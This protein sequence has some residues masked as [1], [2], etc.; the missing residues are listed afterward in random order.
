MKTDVARIAV[1]LLLAMSL[2]VT[3]VQAEG[4]LDGIDPFI[5]E[6]IRNGAMPGAVVLVARNGVVVKEQAYGYA[7][8]FADDKRTPLGPIPM[9]TDT[10][11]DIASISKLFTAT[12]MMQL[13]DQG[14]F[15]LDDPVV[16]YLPEFAYGGREKQQ[17]T[18]RQLMTHSSGFESWLPLYERGANRDDRIHAVLRHPL[19]GQ[20]GSKCVYS[21]LNLIVLGVLVEELSGQRLDAYVRQ[22]ITEPLGLHDTMY[23][24]PP[25]LRPRIAATEYQRGRGLVWGRVHDENAWSFDGVAGHAGVFSTARDLTVFAQMMLNGG[26]YQGKRI[27]SSS[28]V[29][30]MGQNHL[31]SKSGD[32]HGLGWELNQGWYMDAL[33]DPF[34]LGHTGFTGTSIVVSPGSGTIL[35]VLTNRV[36][37]TRETPSINPVRRGVARQV[38]LSIP[39]PIPW[40]DGAW[41]AGMGDNLQ[42]TMTLAA[43][44][45]QGGTL[46]FDTWYRIEQDRDYGYVEASRDGLMWVPVHSGFT[47]SGYWQRIACDLPPGT[48]QVRFRY[49]TNESINGRG[50][51]VHAPNVEDVQGNKVQQTR[52]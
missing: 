44:L 10:I 40:R 23:N 20:P 30:Q 37:P 35:L 1:G 49:S 13:H 50:W 8:Q 45:P 33:A 48:R 19:Q 5:Q 17:V 15:R 28:A 31:P 14:R 9:R 3:P 11:F 25:A 7:V 36:H 32:Q 24:P 43:D 27:L 16:K 38:A 52:K 34:T 4:P 21:D 22:H 42:N 18:V 29:R 47:G 51:F 41:F 26:T 39:V 2:M 12:A 46:T 6:Q